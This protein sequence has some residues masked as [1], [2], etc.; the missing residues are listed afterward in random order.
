MMHNCGCD[1]SM[2]EHDGG[3]KRTHIMLWKKNKFTNVSEVKPLCG[4]DAYKIH[5]YVT[6]YTLDGKMYLSSQPSLDDV[7]LSCL[8]MFT[9]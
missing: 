5:E 6:A 1:M 9:R 8:D 3:C 4:R 2:F 7:C